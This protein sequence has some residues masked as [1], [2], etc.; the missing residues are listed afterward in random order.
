[1]NIRQISSLESEYVV[2]LFDKYRTFYRQSSDLDLARTFIQ[3]RLKNKESVIFAA[4]IEENGKSVPV[5]FTQLYPNYS[6]IRAVKNWILNDL[7]VEPG[8]RNR[9]IGTALIRKAMEFARW[10]GAQFVELSTATDNFIA[11][12]LYEGMGFIKQ[13]FYTD[14]FTYRLILDIQTQR[15]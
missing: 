10:E 11:Q 9:H 1:M 15:S 8:Y 4:S 12:G 5:G 13:S 7:Y 2:G 3:T 14:F 6:S